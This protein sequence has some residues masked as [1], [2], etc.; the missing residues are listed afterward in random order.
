MYVT[1]V[2]PLRLSTVRIRNLA[3]V[4]DLS[5]SPGPGFTAVT[6]ETGSGKSIIVGALK[7]L[8]GERADK[9][10]I[11]A[12]EEACTV[13]GSFEVRDAALLN[14]QLEDFG[15]EP[16]DEGLLL[17]KRVMTTSGTNRQFINGTA[18][19]LN[20]LKSLGDGLVDLHGPHDHQ[21]LLSQDLQRSLLDAFAHA[22]STLALYAQTYAKRT[23][24]VRALADL[25]G[26]EAAF[27]RLYAATRSKLFGVVL[28]ILRRQD[29]AEEVIQEAYVKIWNSA[30]QF[31]PNLSSPI[32]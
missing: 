23:E 16:C 18:T 32:T 13:E 12:G 9:S 24:L 22:S 30:G 8:I 3:L 17:I 21:S 27:E 11:R 26:D 28:R 20:V 7:L 15:V 19:T 5:W 31:N 4:E 14:A 10:L 29:L 2:T 25:H 1:G 6:G